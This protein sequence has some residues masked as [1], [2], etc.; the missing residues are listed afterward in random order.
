MKRTKRAIALIIAVVLAVGLLAPPR[1]VSREERRELP[2][3]GREASG[4]PSGGR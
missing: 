2:R 4:G 1:R 3:E